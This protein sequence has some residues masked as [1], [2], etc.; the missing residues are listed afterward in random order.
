MGGFRWRFWRFGY[1][2]REARSGFLR[3]HYGMGGEDFVTW[4]CFGFDFWVMVK[5]TPHGGKY[6]EA[7]PSR[8][9]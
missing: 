5:T 4:V 9:D 8:E 6:W 7:V 1:G 3:R 2:N